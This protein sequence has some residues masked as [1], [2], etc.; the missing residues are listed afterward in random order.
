VT[1][2][3]DFLFR[4]FIQRRFGFGEDEVEAV[5]AVE[6]PVPGGGGSKI[7]ILWLFFL[8]L[9]LENLLIFHP[10]FVPVLRAVF[11]VVVRPWFRRWAANF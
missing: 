4:A 10:I 1:V 11:V 2:I 5:P 3:E 7:V 8:T 9:L 6:A